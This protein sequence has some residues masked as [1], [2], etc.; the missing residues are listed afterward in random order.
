MAISTTHACGAGNPLAAINDRFRRDGVG[1][2]IMLT[3][4]IAQLGDSAVAAI[5][6]AVRQFDAFTPDNDPY[7][8]HDFGAFDWAGQRLFWKIDYY[9]QALQFASEDPTDS[10]I[11]CRVLT[12]MLAEEY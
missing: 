11:T 5:R 10:A 7:G 9:D 1:G 6:T 2:E 4:G 12:I 3:R 8:E